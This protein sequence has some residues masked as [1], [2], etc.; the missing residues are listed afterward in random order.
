MNQCKLT[1][2]NFGTWLPCD[3]MQVICLLVDLILQLYPYRLFLN[4]K[5]FIGM[6]LNFGKRLLL[7]VDPKDCSFRRKLTII[8]E[9]RSWLRVLDSGVIMVIMMLTERIFSTFL[10][11]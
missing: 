4:W 3:S 8:I 7:V 11:V 6:A 9:R 10:G 1:S 5:P 2:G